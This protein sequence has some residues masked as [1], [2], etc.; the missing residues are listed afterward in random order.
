MTPMKRKSPLASTLWRTRVLAVGL[1]GLQACNLTPFD[2]EEAPPAT[3]AVQ[4][5]GTGVDNAGRISATADIAGTPPGVNETVVAESLAALPQS[6]GSSPAATETTPAPAAPPVAAP[7]DY[8]PSSMTL[9]FGDEFNGTQL[10][11]SKWCT[12]YQ[13]GGGPDLQVPDAGCV[14]AQW[15]GTL[16]RLNDEQQRYVDFN[17]TGQTMHVV[18]NGVLTL[19]ATKTGKT[20]YPYESAMI[21]SKMVFAPTSTTR[22]YM[23]ARMR[24]A[25]VVG[26]WPA[27]WLAPSVKS[28]GTTSASSEIDMM[29]GPLNRT[30]ETAEIIRLGSQP[31]HGTTIPWGTVSYAAPGYDPV[32]MYWHASSSLRSRWLEIGVN[33]SD[34][35][36]CYFIDGLK[37]ACEPYEWSFSLEQYTS[38]AH[39]LL[40]LAIGGNWAGRDGIDDARFPTGFEID[41]VRVYS[42]PR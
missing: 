35:D 33:W 4:A 11:R 30:T 18:S 5:D 23:T 6:A 34:S 8:H 3:T 36:V 12:R 26:T 1:V 2:N 14:T 22:L 25:D 24:L 9:I 20:D 41:H 13:F 19:R 29:E 16:D 37:V 38:P 7:S 27:F 10:D 32:R 15:S 42:G 40:N 39:L 17:R 28:D 31:H 21:R